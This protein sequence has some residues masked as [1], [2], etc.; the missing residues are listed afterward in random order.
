MVESTSL[1]Q[2]FNQVA[3]WHSVLDCTGLGLYC[4]LVYHVL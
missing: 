3:P 1:N 4:C 2:N